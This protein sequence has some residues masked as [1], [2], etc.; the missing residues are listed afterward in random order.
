MSIRFLTTREA[1]ERLRETPAT[2]SRRAARGE[3]PGAV[4]PGKSWLI[5]AADVEALL[6]PKPEPATPGPVFRSP[7]Q[8]R[9][10][11]AHGLI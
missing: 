10:A 6:R 2:T 8:E 11:R 1:A 9:L 4:K 7:R 5:P 3:F